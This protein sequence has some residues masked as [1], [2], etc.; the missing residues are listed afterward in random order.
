LIVIIYTIIAY[1]CTDSTNIADIVD[2]GNPLK[3]ETVANRAPFFRAWR[4]STSNAVKFLT[5]P[6][7][8]S[9]Q[10]LFLALGAS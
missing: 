6:A 5:N 2:I 10:F 7:E 3:I 8:R 1:C 4:N 9:A